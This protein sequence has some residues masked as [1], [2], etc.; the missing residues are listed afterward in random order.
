MTCAIRDSA[1]VKI[2]RRIQHLRSLHRK[3]YIK[4][5]VLG[6]YLVLDIILDSMVRML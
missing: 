1:E 6:K 2:W 4:I 5:G 3:S